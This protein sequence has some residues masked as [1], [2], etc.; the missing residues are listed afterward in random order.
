[1]I[2]AS[3][4]RVRAML[5]AVAPNMS[6]FQEATRCTDDCAQSCAHRSPCM[7]API[8]AGWEAATSVSGVAEGTWFPRQVQASV[9]ARISFADGRGGHHSPVATAGRWPCCSMSAKCG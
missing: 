6:D 4:S 8:P 1:M 5:G 7:L 2:H 9:T 3:C